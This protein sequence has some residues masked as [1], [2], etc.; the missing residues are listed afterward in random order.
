MSPGWDELAA[1][2]RGCTRCAELAVTRTQVVP[3]VR[4]PGAR[5]LLVGEAPGAEEDVAG[6]PFVGRSGRLLDELLA[7]A[8]LQ[9]GELAVAN[10][11]KCRPPR[12]RTPRRA[13]VEACRGWLTA[14][15]AAADPAV[16]VSL[17]GTALQWFLGAH[18]RIGAS[19]GVV[20]DWHGRPLVA[21]YHPSAAIRFGPRGAPLAALRSDLRSVAVLL[22]ASGTA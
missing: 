4:P 13:E 15:V 6:V 22:D 11:V 2:V 10:V 21:T 16:L 1:A 14:Q 9:R 7:D 20:H 5:V 3:G 19:R 18:A 12:N 17:G 8:G